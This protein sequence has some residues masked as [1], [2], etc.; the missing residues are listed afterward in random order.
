MKVDLDKVSYVLGQSVGGD[1]RR[2][3]FEID[4]KL[5]ADSFIE[6]F[7]GKESEM[8]VGEMR[9]IMQNFQRAM[10]DKKQATRMES[11]KKNVEA[12]KKFLEENSKKEGVKT[13]ESGLQ[14]K[15][16]IEGSGK[17]PTA[18]DTVETHYEGK[19]LDGKIFDSSYK[20]GQ[21]TTFPLNGVIKGWTEALQLMAEGSK[22]E[23]YIPSELAYGS[24]GSGGTIEPYSTLVFTVELVAI[25]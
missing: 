13:T 9:H 1:F 14:Y 4:P 10:E 23:L 16:I 19:T 7:N 20:R 2:Q 3:G 25:K 15:V 22:Y 12:G 17:K 11:G 8:P 5:F 24:A 6:A 18:T 21:T